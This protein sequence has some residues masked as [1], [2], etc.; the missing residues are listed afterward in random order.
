M[1]KPECLQECSCGD[2]MEVH[3]NSHD[4]RC[5][6]CYLFFGFIEREHSG[7]ETGDGQG[8]PIRRVKRWTAE[9]G[10]FVE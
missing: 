5:Y 9:R 3:C 4:T 2:I 7:M 6:N 8:F 1:G 10:E